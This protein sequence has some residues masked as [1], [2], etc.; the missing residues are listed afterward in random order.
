MNKVFIVG[1]LTRAPE[2]RTTPNGVSVTTFNVAVT[3]RMNR[4]EADFIN[5]VTW[6]G[7]ADNCAK[8]LVQ[9]QQVAVAGEIRTRNYEAQDGTRRYVTEIQADD[10]EFLA[11]PGGGAAN[12]S[13]QAASSGYEDNNIPAAPK[14]DG[15]IFAAEMSDVL[16]DDEELPF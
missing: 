4:E 5:V 11:R 8:Y 3:R 2:A 16:L 10:V 6:R 7:L 12:Y 9:G 15:D 13:G 14:E 1:R